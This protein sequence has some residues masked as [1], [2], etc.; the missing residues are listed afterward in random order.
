MAADLKQIHPVVVTAPTARNGIT[1][2]QRLLNSSRQIIV[3]GENKHL[4][5][6][7]TCL[8][9]SAAGIHTSGAAELG[10]ARK[11]FLTETTEFWSSSLWPDTGLYLQRT[12]EGFARLVD[13]Y[14]VCS[15]RYGFSRW[16][17][18]H[19]FSSLVDFD[20]FFSLLPAGQF[21]YVYRNPFDVARS[22]KARQ[23]A[24]T[25]ADFVRLASNWRESVAA[26]RR[27][28]RANLL[29]IKYEALVAD[30]EPW[31]ARIEEFTGIYNI[32]RSVMHRRFNTFCGPTEC[33]CSPTEYIPPAPLTDAEAGLLREHAA[34]LLAEE[35]YMD[36]PCSELA[37]ALV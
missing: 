37:A 35:G 29:V 22:A 14:E 11:R 12:I 2:L 19:P 13:V 33:G 5:E 17:I 34:D 25:P 3:Y 24:T 8:V 16:G 6:H 27:A 32:D 4:C 7:A 30:P 21:I 26:V 23:F 31:L 18:K 9:Y 36:T 28:Q 15:Q 10:L 1:L 20:R